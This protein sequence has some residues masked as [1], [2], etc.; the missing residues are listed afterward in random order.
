MET[1][2]NNLKNK[3]IFFLSQNFRAAALFIALILLL[4]GFFLLYNFKYKKIEEKIS[5]AFKIEKPALATGGDL[6]KNLR[7]IEK[8]YDNI[9]QPS[10]EKINKLL[11][12]WK[13]NEEFFPLLEK[14]V[15]R[16]GLLISSLSLEEAGGGSEAAMAENQP[17]D[18]K[19]DNSAL[20][21]G[22]GAIKASL[23]ISG[24]DYAGLKNLL[25]SFENNL[26]IID[27]KSV[28]F[29]PSSKSASLELLTYYLKNENSELKDTSKLHEDILIDP[30]FMSLKE[31]GAGIAP[32]I[33]AG[34]QNIFE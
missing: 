23:E 9:S 33:S 21:D 13:N 26:I 19:Q 8:Q 11:P 6:L 16:N 3:A 14:I 34:K 18:K 12:S 15:L 1:K 30:K 10:K 32:E 28:N 7:Q 22:I 27:L 31:A 17:T 25:L 4:A 29:S 24:L 2:K 5:Y 20:P